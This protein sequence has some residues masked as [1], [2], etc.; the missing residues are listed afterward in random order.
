MIKM[1]ILFNT[2]RKE[3]SLCYCFGKI[4]LNLIILSFFSAESHI[5]MW[6]PER[7]LLGKGET[8]SYNSKWQQLWTVWS[9]QV[10]PPQ[11]CRGLQ[12]STTRFEAAH[13]ALC[14]W[15]DS[16]HCAAPRGR[17][18][19]HVSPRQWHPHGH[20]GQAYAL[21]PTLVG[22]SHLLSWAS[23]LE[24]TLSKFTSG[25]HIYNPAVCAELFANGE[26]GF[27]YCFDITT[28]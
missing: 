16:L 24:H 3:I 27:D 26:S 23:R 14:R 22:Q 21:Q 6:L 12:A 15:Q 25:G 7:V 20:V 9:S 1:L 8:L 10:S 11:P 19:A 28:C 17:Q 13:L 2:W 5:I 4:P 18:G